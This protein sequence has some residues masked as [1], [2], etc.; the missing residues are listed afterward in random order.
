MIIITA[1]WNTGMLLL[2]T[3]GAIM[4][5]GTILL[6]FNEL[7]EQWIDFFAFAFEI[8]IIIIFLIGGI[9]DKTK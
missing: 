5:G 2:I 6:F 1:L 9:T 8:L 7:G 4:Q 3:I